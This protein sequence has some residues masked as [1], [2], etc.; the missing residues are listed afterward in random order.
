[1]LRG[2]CPV[3]LST[4][5]YVDYVVE[6]PRDMGVTATIDNGRLRVVGLTGAVEASSDNSGIEV[7]DVEGP[8]HIQSDNGSL[9]GEGLSGRRSRRTRTTDR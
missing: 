1:M 8:V 2:T 7:V 5:C 4:F 9:R 3:F 6:V